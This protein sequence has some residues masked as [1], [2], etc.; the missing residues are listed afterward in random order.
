M[1]D[2]EAG[3]R[4]A[5]AS[6]SSNDEA[7]L[8]R[9]AVTA[10]L[11]GAIASGELSFKGKTTDEI[12][13]ESKRFLRLFAT[14][15][16]P[17][18]LMFDHTDDLLREARIFLRRSKWSLAALLYATYFEHAVNA[19]LV[20]QVRRRYLSKGAVTQMIREVSFAGKIGWLMEL[21]EMKPLN[22]IHRKRLLKLAEVRNGFVHYKWHAVGER[23]VEPASSD[24]DPVK[25][26]LK[27]V[28][29]TVS[30]LRRYEEEMSYGGQRKHIKTVVRTM[31]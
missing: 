5:T 22:P 26:C 30:Y 29:K 17:I 25:R 11:A 12:K 8:V 2:N 31:S 14:G 9:A 3:N 7:R 18:H 20:T 27:D 21:M 19:V 1:T 6:V 24:D 15:V 16:I 13:E 28:E 10:V 4:T 23:N